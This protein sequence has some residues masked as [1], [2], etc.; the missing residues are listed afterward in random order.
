MTRTQTRTVSMY[1][2][3]IRIE[4]EGVEQ[5]GRRNCDMTWAYGLISHVAY[6]GGNQSTFPVK[7]KLH[8]KKET[9]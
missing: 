4:G 2:L 8:V 3:Q 1:I 9:L 5:V 7:G 6:L